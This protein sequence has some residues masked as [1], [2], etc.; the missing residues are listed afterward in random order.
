MK[1][2]AFLLKKITICFLV[3]IVCGCNTEKYIHHYDVDVVNPS[4]GA[5][6]TPIVMELDHINMDRIIDT[7]SFSM[8]LS[9]DKY[10]YYRENHPVKK[11]TDIRT[12]SE[13]ISVEKINQ[14]EEIALNR[15]LL[16]Y[17]CDLIVGLKYDVFYDDKFESV[18][19]VVMGY[20]AYYKMIRPAT[21]D[22][23]WMLNFMNQGNVYNYN[24]I[25]Q[26]TIR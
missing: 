19:V 11:T 4:I 20:P 18:K 9:T 16:K 3:F 1:K 22:D 26:D 7:I 15:V 14:Y 10:A 17:K 12:Y 23:V 2:K 25:K 6:T 21:K 5:I 13:Q 24:V 8:K